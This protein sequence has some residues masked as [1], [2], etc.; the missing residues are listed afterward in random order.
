MHDV[1]V[2]GEV[3]HVVGRFGKEDVAEGMMAIVRHHHI[4]GIIIHGIVVD[5]VEGELIKAVVISKADVCIVV[6]GIGRVREADG[7]V[8][9]GIGVMVDLDVWLNLGEW[10]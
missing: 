7:F 2:C 1:I 3:D 4:V 6:L 5:V 8:E 9:L 10:V